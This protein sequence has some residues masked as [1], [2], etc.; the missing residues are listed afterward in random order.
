M[1]G[2]TAAGRGRGAG[3][4]RSAGDRQRAEPAAQ[5]RRRALG[6]R[7]V[8]RVVVWGS[9][10]RSPRLAAGVVSSPA[11]RRRTRRPRRPG[12]ADEAVGSGQQGAPPGAPQLGHG[13]VAAEGAGVSR[14]SNAVLMAA[15]GTRVGDRPCTGSRRP[16]DPHDG[17]QSDEVPAGY[18]TA[19]RA[20]ERVGPLAEG[21]PDGLQPR[22]DAPACCGRSAPG[23]RPGREQLVA[24][25]REAARMPG[26]R[27]G[28]VAHGH[29]DLAHLG[30]DVGVL[31][32]EEVALVHPAD[33]LE[34]G[35][36]Y[37]H[38]GA[39]DPIGLLR[40]LV[41]R[42]VLD[43]LVCARDQP[44]DEQCLAPRRSQV[45]G[46]GAGSDDPSVVVEDAGADDAGQRL[47]VEHRRERLDVLI[48]DARVRVEE[49]HVRR[50]S[51]TRAE[52]A[53]V[54]EAAVARRLHAADRQIAMWARGSSPGEAL[55]TTVTATCGRPASG[56]THPRSV[57]ELR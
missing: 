47:P 41:G 45:P 30:A 34:R 20:H 3:S 31:A 39:R 56:S 22:R 17:A 21:D 14:D 43:H 25:R 51:F 38:A 18:G 40:D 50:P 49:Q 28:R 53:A 11:R 54:G 16:P 15:R 33:A 35:A 5:G 57:S 42:R 52:V 9:R 46:S 55:S 1:S 10:R 32:V 44:V 37:Q 23:S 12:G 6:P 19:A 4:R 7:L 13:S 26:G 2:A 48:V 36:P 24:R 29:A 27:L 8:G